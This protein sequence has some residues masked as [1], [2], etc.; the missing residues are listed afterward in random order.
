MGIM[1]TEL[2]QKRRWVSKDSR[3]FAIAILALTVIALVVGGIG[4]FKVIVAGAILGVLRS[5]LAAIPGVR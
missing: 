2:Q 1:Q 3:W 4:P 5:R